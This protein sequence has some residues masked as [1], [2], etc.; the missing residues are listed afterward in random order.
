MREAAKRLGYDLSKHRARQV[1]FDDLNAFDLVVAMD[2]ENLSD[3]RRLCKTQTQL[4]KLRFFCE[5]IPE[6]GFT[7]GVPDPYY[8]GGYDRT[9]SVVLAGVRAILKKELD[10]AL[11]E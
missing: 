7:D 2:M 8:E 11:D 4:E 6:L 5:Y 1:T 9:F 10:L 3:L